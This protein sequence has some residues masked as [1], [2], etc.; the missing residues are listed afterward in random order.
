MEWKG[1]LRRGLRTA[2]EITSG[3]VGMY[4]AAKALGAMPSELG[5]GIVTA[6]GFMMAA[7]VA[8][9]LAIAL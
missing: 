2:G 7:S 8:A 5:A 4:G 9:P 1:P 6:R 3:L